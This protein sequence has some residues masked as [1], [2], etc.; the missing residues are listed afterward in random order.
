MLKRNASIVIDDR[1]VQALHVHA[2]GVVFGWGLTGISRYT[3]CARRFYW[4]SYLRFVVNA[5]CASQSQYCEA[6]LRQQQ[7]IYQVVVTHW[8]YGIAPR[9]LYR[10]ISYRLESNRLF[11]GWGP[12]SDWCQLYIYIL[13][14]KSEAARR[15]TTSFERPQGTN[16]RLLICSQSLQA[17]T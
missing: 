12:Y 17:T 6:G 11:A 1:T 9:H 8:K 10:S 2:A 4:G 14:T 7:N 13:T 16:R 5:E 15:R 3:W